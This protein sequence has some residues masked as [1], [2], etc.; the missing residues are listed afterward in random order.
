MT[1]ATVHLIYESDV[2][3]VLPAIRVPTL[4]IHRVEATGF[5]VEHGRYL[6]A[7]IPGAVYVELPG[8][9]NLI[10]AGDRDAIVDEIQQFVTGTRPAPTPRRALATVL[11]TDIVD[12]TRI[13][14][15]RETARGGDCSRSTT[16]S[17]AGTSSGRVG[18]W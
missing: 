5:G 9:D 14:A 13:A 7:H 1:A 12:S 4:V 11:F 16:R 18:E 10:W 6:A 17:P 2:R 3:D 8:V 15:A